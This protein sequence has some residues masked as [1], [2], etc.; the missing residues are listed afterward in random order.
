MSQTMISIEQ[1]GALMRAAGY[2]EVVERAWAPGTV[3]DTHTHPFDVNA[4]MVAGEMTLTLAGEAPRR[5][6]AGDTFQ[7]AADVPHAEQYGPDGA[8]YWVARR[9]L[10]PPA[11]A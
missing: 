2:D 1:L 10:E 5:L 11:G 4:L 7:L 8:T 6:R 9:M 3:V